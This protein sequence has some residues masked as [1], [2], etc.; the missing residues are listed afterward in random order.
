MSLRVFC[1]HEISSHIFFAY[2]AYFKVL[3][4]FKSYASESWLGYSAYYFVY[5]ASVKRVCASFAYYFAYYITYS[6]YY[7][8]FQVQ[9]HW[10]VCEYS[11]QGETDFQNASREAHE[12]LRVSKEFSG[13]V[14]FCK[15]WMKRNYKVRGPPHGLVNLK[16]LEFSK[17]T[18]VESTLRAFHSCT[19]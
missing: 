11:W 17:R 6:A 1:I 2:S 19:L 8:A 14:A 18:L 5:S 13:P 3:Q 10:Q 9:V 16:R 7:F 15:T 4:Y 12:A